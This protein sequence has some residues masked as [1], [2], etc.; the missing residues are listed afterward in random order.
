MTVTY[1]LVSWYSRSVRLERL[2]KEWDADPQG[3]D[4]A[5]TTHIETGMVAYENGFRKKLIWLIYI[6]P[7]VFVITAFYVTNTG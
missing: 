5:R 2:E 6:V 7:V 1:F 3:D 4:A